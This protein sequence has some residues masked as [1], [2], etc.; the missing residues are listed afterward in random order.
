MSS[1]P[2]RAYVNSFSSLLQM[3]SATLV[4]VRYSKTRFL[5]L[6]NTADNPWWLT[7]RLKDIV[8]MIYAQ[9]ISVPQVAYLVVHIQEY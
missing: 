9:K 7:L 6:F 2:N 1:K 8:D 5:G 3:F 4:M